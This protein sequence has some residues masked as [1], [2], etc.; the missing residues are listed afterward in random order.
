VSRGTALVLVAAVAVLA[1][2]VVFGRAPEQPSGP[3]GSSYATTAGGVAAYATLLERAGHDVRR[4]RAPLDERRPSPGETVVIVDG[5][6]LPED[7]LAALDAQVRVGGRAVLAGSAMRSLPGDAGTDARS[8]SR[9]TRPVGRGAYVLVPDA[10]PLRNRALGRGD[11]AARA[12]T[13][14]GPPSR[15]VAFVESVHGYHDERGLAALPDAVITCLWLLGLATLAFLVLRGRR[16]G[17]PEA[18]ARELAPPRRAH[19][20]AL[21]AALARTKDKD[22]ILN[23]D[24]T[25]RKPT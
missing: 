12:L 21:A 24:P 23:P 6:R 17:P 10:T 14:A 16:L 4:L 1:I 8:A 9:G 11:N 20:E 19:V 3:R 13:L 2:A 25:E 5:T 22:T 18:A 15:R 7:E